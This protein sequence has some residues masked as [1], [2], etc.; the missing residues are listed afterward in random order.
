MQTLKHKQRVMNMNKHDN[1]IYEYHVNRARELRMIAHQHA[2]YMNE[3]DMREYIIA[4]RQHIEHA[5]RIRV[6]S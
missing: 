2:L 1:R 3:H 4:A 6:Q 5:K